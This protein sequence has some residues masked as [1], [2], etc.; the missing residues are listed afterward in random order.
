MVSVRRLA[1]LGERFRQRDLGPSDPLVD[2]EI[3]VFGRVGALGNARALGSAHGSLP[4][5][6]GSQQRLVLIFRRLLH[7]GG[8]GLPPRL[9]RV[10]GIAGVLS[11]LACF[12]GAHVNLLWLMRG[13]T[14]M[15]PASNIAG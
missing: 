6:L 13:C 15:A 12:L 7:S 9:Q 10:D 5:C 8:G 1:C 11:S 14:R 3:L 2:F 4:A